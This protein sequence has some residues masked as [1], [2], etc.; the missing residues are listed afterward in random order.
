MFFILLP[1]LNRTL[2]FTM[3]IH[4]AIPAMDEL[5]SL[6]TTLACLQQQQVAYEVHIYVC[7]N[8]PASF[9]E[10]KSKHPICKANRQTFEQ[11][12]HLHL[13]NVYVEDCFSPTYALPAD[14]Q[15]VGWV[16]KRLFDRITAHCSDEDL[17]ISLDADTEIRPNYLQ[18]IAT[19]MQSTPLLPALAVPY[20]HN[21]TG[22]EAIDRA[23]LRYEFYLRTYAINLLRIR[24]PYSFTALGSA[25]V[26]RAAAY[27]KVGGITPLQS[28]EDFYLLQKLRKMSTLHVWCEERV[29][30]AAR[31]STRVPFGTGPAIK[32]G[33]NGNW[34]SYPIF[35]PSLFDEI[36]EVYEQIPRL[37]TEDIHSSFFDFLCQRFADTHFLE[38][39]RKN[40]K[41]LPM[42]CKAFHHKV[43][44]L[45]IFQ[46]LKQRQPELSL[47]DQEALQQNLHLLNYSNPIPDITC[48]DVNELNVIRDFL[49]E[50]ENILLRNYE[51]ELMSAQ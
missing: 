28:G 44:A 14:K 26:M 41:T 5:H 37:Y 10:D 6:F 24:S 25:I 1:L 29:Y 3:K 11:L 45:R 39:L 23:I 46:H 2:F 12:Q 51:A 50:Q 21:L 30:P 27:K 19:T 42:F 43:D 32:K 13:P 22:N 20:Y 4:V 17:L 49:V 38:P 34:S 16:R 9:Y 33:L 36:R 31:E 40:F 47:S 18:S 7:I 8:N 15:G 35:S 48:A